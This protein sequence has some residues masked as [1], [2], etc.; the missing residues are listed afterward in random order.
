MEIPEDVFSF[1]A[2]GVN[3]P[4]GHPDHRCEQGV[5][6]LSV[7]FAPKLDAE[8]GAVEVIVGVPPESPFDWTPERVAHM[9]GLAAAAFQRGRVLN[10]GTRQFVYRGEVQAYEDEDEGQ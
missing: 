6:G 1:V 7:V 2:N 3:P 10:L 4:H 8:P 5:L 9:L